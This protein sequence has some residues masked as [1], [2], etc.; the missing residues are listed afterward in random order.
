MKKSTYLLSTILLLTFTA[1]LTAQ[2][3]NDQLWYCW[4]ET[5]KLEMIDQ[6]RALSKELL[7]LCKSENFPFPIYTWQASPFTYELWSPIESLADIKKIGEEW[8]KILVKLGAD[9]Q[10]AFNETK[11]HHREFTCTIKNDLQYTPANPDFGRNEFEYCL[12]I[13]LFLKPG[14][15]KEFEKAVKEFNKERAEKDYGSYVFYATGGF[16]Y[17]RPC[18]IVMISDKNEESFLKS[19]KKINEVMSDEIEAYMKKIYPLMRKPMIN[20]DW[21][22]LM[23]LSYT[24]PD[25]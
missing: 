7:E 5:V 11:I 3:N 18:Y 10:A 2:E 24:N 21:Y 4:E 1:H 12:W 20:H 14:K 16:G 15:Q 13:E 19:Q 22:L 6:Y 9:K 8:D 23:D 17:E 25:N